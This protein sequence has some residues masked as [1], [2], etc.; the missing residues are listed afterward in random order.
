M[1]NSDFDKIVFH[2][3]V[4]AHGFGK[5]TDEAYE[6]GLQ[7]HEEGDDYATI[8]FEIVARKLCADLK[9][10]KPIC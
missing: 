6:L 1:R 8:A 2:D 10:E 7:L 4:V 5:P 9:E 3:F